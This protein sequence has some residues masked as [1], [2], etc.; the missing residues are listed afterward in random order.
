M[1]IKSTA[2]YAAPASLF[3]LLFFGAAIA[4]AQTSTSTENNPPE[5]TQQ[6][7][8]NLV[9][10]QEAQA[11]VID[12][13]KNMRF[14]SETVIGRFESI[15]ARIDS[16]SA[17]MEQE[18]YDMA[19]TRFYT[20][21]AKGALALAQNELTGTDA[22]IAEFVTSTDAWATWFTVRDSILETKALLE[23][24]KALLEEAVAEMHLTEEE[25]IPSGVNEAL[26]PTS[27]EPEAI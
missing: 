7:V 11:D 20:N 17:Q 5:T 24:T 16:R 25:G 10:T 1:N 6:P 19:D 15:I 26:S 12:L 2:L 21:E 13:A 22:E 9:L 14:K 18:G 27:S 3:I 23:R 8:V 4:L